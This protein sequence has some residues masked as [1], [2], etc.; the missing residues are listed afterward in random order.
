MS[1]P[2]NIPA[3]LRQLVDYVMLYAYDCED[4]LKI[5]KE[6]INHCGFRLRKLFERR[7]YSTKLTILNDLDFLI[8]DYWEK[9]TGT[10]VFI[11]ETKLHSDAKWCRKPVGWGLQEYNA[12]RKKEK[13][14]NS[15]A[16][17]S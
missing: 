16:K 17:D 4:W 11:D 2:K 8:K 5:R 9:N 15:D 3:E 12:K 10:K 7:H 6:I 13:A 14:K 1:D